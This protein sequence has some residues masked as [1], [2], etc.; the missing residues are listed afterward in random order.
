MAETGRD[1]ERRRWRRRRLAGKL[2]NLLRLVKGAFTFE[3]ALDYVLWKVER[4]SGVR[5]AVS[6]C[7]ARN[8]ASIAG[9]SST[10]GSKIA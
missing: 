10:A 6:P 9:V 2:L 7:C 4:H 8:A 1:A 5:V 3:G